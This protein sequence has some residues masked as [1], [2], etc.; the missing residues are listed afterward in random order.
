MI[1]SMPSLPPK[2]GLDNSVNIVVE[3]LQKKFPEVTVDFV[4]DTEDLNFSMMT[5][6]VNIIAKASGLI[7]GEAEAAPVPETGS[8]GQTSMA[9]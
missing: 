8:T 4:Y 1:A 9:A 5:N 7:P 2:E 3:A 6:Y